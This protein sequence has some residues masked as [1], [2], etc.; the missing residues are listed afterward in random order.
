M[1]SLFGKANKSPAKKR[2]FTLLLTLSMILGMLPIFGVGALAAGP[3]TDVELMSLTRTAATAAEAGNMF[4]ADTGVYADASNL[5]AWSNNTQKAVGGTGRT[6]IVFNNAQTTGGWK[7]ISVAGINNA[8]AFQIQFSTA[9]YDN[10]RFTCRQKS[11]GSGPDGFLLAYSVGSPTGPYTAIEGS[12]TGTNGIPAIQRM[13]NDTYAAL[14]DTYDSFVLPSEMDD[15]AVVYLRV[16]FDGLDN[17]GQNGNTS[18]ND[19]VIIGD[20][21]GS[22]GAV[23]NKNALNALITEALTKVESEYTPASWAAFA[24][25]L[26]NAQA[27]AADSSATQ[28]DVNTA[29]TAL[30]STMNALIRPGDVVDTIN[31][32]GNQTLTA[33]DTSRTFLADSSGLDFHNGQLYAVDNG[34]GRFWIL[35]VAQDGSLSIV[36]G[37]ENGKRAR[38]KSVSSSNGPDAEGISVDGD[39]LVYIASE[40][41]NSRS[42]VNWNVILQLDPWTSGNDIVAMREWDITASLP[43]VNTNTG[44]EAVEWV[45]FADIDG[46]LFDK[47]TNAPFDS[48]NYPGATAGGVFFVALEANGHVYAYVLYNNETYVQIA[49]INTKLGGAMALDWDTYEK[50][51]WVAADNGFGCRSAIL[52]FTGAS[53]PGIVHVN[54]PSGLNT[55][56]NYEGFAIADASYTVNGQRPVYRF[57]DGVNSR[58]LTIGSIDCDYG[59][60]S[61]STLLTANITAVAE[62]AVIGE[63]ADYMIYLNN[64]ADVQ[65]V[66]LSFTVDGTVLRGSEFIPQGRFGF[67][68]GSGSTV[69]WTQLAGDMWR[70]TVRLSVTGEPLTAATADVLKLSFETLKLGD[71][72]VTIESIE[73]IGWDDN[74]APADLGAGIEEGEATIVIIEWFS[75]FDINKDGGVDDLDLLYILRLFGAVRGVSVSDWDAPTGLSDSRSRPVTFAMVDVNGD[76][77]I[78]ILDILELIANYK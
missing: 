65:Q 48:A 26:S 23:V 59:T 25:A 17:L 45:S 8:D 75:K 20:A 11:T 72:V 19:I 5:T 39:G 33:W 47:N 60:S 27:V 63:T 67:T 34:T 70:G 50:V 14:R 57:E 13:S 9:G 21:R 53:V 35:D 44:I 15:E 46:K 30:L 3:E 7:P 40:R 71:A 2:A 31:W 74:N 29:R 28:Q 61:G 18:I 56:G 64:A 6:P 54:P 42:S 76:N 55:S 62:T 12:R 36:P 32:P 73:V 1:K 24:A 38:F 58:A 4:G 77:A 41:D 66:N 52:K 78:D 51:L 43:Q 16:V 69:I 22:G 10:I 49:D 68:P 37:F